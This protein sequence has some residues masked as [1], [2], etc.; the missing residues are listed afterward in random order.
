MELS[1]LTILSSLRGVYLAGLV[2]PLLGLCGQVVAQVAANPCGAPPAILQ[3]AVTHI[4]SMQQEQWLGDAMADQVERQYHPAKNLKQNEYLQTIG[5]R[6]LAALPPT[7]I[8]F[9]FILVDS[10]EI[11]AF[12]LAGGRVYLTRKLVATSLNEDEVAGVIAHEMGHILT[13]QF[14]IETTADLKRLLNITSVGDRADIYAKYQRLVDARMSDQHSSA[15]DT[16]EKQDLADRIS[17]YA[18]AA[19]GYDPRMFPGIL[20][21]APDNRRLDNLRKLV[22]EL[23]SGCRS[24]AATKRCAFDWW[25]AEVVADQSASQVS[26][27][28][29]RAACRPDQSAAADPGAR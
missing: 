26:L 3:S 27:S 24:N 8:Q 18:A 17:V 5:D 29:I 11:N 20:N 23:P 16:D 1:S 22:A 2:M 7:Q 25:R 14:G 21:I 15:G 6:L 13:H 12:S 19:A 10:P 28:A 9:R 4:F